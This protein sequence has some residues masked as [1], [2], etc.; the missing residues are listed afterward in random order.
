MHVR[1]RRGVITF[2]HYS[3]ASF[4]GQF[5]FIEKTKRQFRLLERCHLVFSV[6]LHA[7]CSVIFAASTYVSQRRSFVLIL[8]A[9]PWYSIFCR[10]HRVLYKEPSCDS[11]H[12][13]TRT[14][15]IKGICG[16]TRIFVVPNQILILL[17][18][19]TC[20][21]WLHIKIYYLRIKLLKQLQ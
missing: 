10:L 17:L 6:V 11:N 20:I 5:L 1:D 12:T 13:H 4:F 14:K 8:W 19:Q 16:T 2:T 18:R 7:A 15:D 9:Y 21:N 3:T